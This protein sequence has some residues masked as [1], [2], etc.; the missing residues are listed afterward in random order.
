MARIC[1]A[2]TGTCSPLFID[3]EIADVGS[4]ITSEVYRNIVSA[5]SNQMPQNSLDGTTPN[6]K[7]T[8]NILLKQPR[9]FLVLKVE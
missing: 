4:K 1:M 2:A 7:M 9:S 8:L 3:A 5:R 6:S